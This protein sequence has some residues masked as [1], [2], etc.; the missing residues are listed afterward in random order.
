MTFGLGS[1]ESDAGV[2]SSAEVAFAARTAP[3]IRA[4]GERD[5]SVLVLPVGS[6]E[7]HGNHLPVATD[8]ILASAVAVAG[9]T[10]VAD[11]VPVLVAPTVWTGYSPHH[12]SFGGTLTGEFGTLLDLLGT[13]ADAALDNG[14]DALLLLNGHGGNRAL[15]D[16]A[17]TVVGR[18]HPGVESLGLT[19]FDLA[20]PFADEVRESDSGGMAHGGEFETSMMRY[21]RPELVRD[22]APAAYWDEP[23]DLAGSDLLEGGPLS[24]YRPFEAYSE[25]GAIGD[26]SLA[27]AEKGKQFFDGVRAELAALLLDV[28]E[29][30]AD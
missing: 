27:S 16:A 1:F 22:D 3:E 19:Y 12:R 13:V 11:D 23:Y 26:P 29:R 15:V 2:E 8:S 28:H 4:L 10:A 18:S 17:V 14:F 21:L 24:V 7:Q 30:N 25:S 6:V 20:A 9:A 5:G